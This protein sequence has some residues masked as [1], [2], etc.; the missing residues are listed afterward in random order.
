VSDPIPFKPVDE[1]I[2]RRKLAEDAGE[3]LSSRAFTT[4]ILNLRKRFFERLMD[5][6]TPDSKMALIER[7]RALESIPQELQILVNDQKMAEARKK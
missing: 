1:S 6:E 5:A 3:L 7:I 2:E 4:S